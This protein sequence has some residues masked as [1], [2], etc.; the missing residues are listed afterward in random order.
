MKA[1]VPTSRQPKKPR[2]RVRGAWCPDR[3]WIEQ[4]RSRWHAEGIENPIVRCP[5]CNRRLR[6]KAC[7]C[8][9]G[10]FVGWRIPPHKAKEK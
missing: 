2:T 5:T 8:V 10:E 7:Y 6:L 3:S 9:G 4:S 1:R